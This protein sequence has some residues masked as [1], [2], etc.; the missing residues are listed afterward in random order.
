MVKKINDEEKLIDGIG[1]QSH[2]DVNYPSINLYERAI[3]ELS[4]TGLKVQVNELDVTISDISEFGF[5]RQ[6]QYYS[7][8]MDV[9]VKYS[10]SVT[11]VVF[12]GTTDDK[13][14]CAMQCPL[15]FNS[16]YTAKPCFYSIVDGF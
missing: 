11:S 6:A 15:L 13:S 14:W 7:N 12:W 5:E 1:M 9:I 16:V 2:L 10:N 3:K 4:E 8:I